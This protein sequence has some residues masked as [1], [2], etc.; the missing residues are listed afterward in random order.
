MF[1]STCRRRRLISLFVGS[2]PN[3][4]LQ[5]PGDGWRMFERL[6]LAAPAAESQVVR[7]FDRIGLRWLG[8]HRD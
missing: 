5:L 8:R 3:M 6:A 1:E 7:Q 2:P 4:P